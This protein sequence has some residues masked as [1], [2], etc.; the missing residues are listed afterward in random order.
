[1]MSQ[2]STAIRFKKV[3]FETFYGWIYNPYTYH[4]QKRSLS[5]HSYFSKSYDENQ[6]R[7][8]RTRAARARDI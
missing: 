3:V 7:S 2:K 8:E 4:R 5:L 6:I 1:M